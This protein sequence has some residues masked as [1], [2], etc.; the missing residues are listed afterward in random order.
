MPTSNALADLRAAI[1]EERITHQDAQKV[2]DRY[3]EFTA[4]LTE[5]QQNGG[6]SPTH[7]EFEAWRDDILLM[8]AIK[9]EGI[10]AE[11]AALVPRRHKT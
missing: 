7:V 9:G 11:S 5:F 8:W 3:Q 1:L 4:K 2:L 10:K 6:K